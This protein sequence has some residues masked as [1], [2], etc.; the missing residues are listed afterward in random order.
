MLL[1]CSLVLAGFTASYAFI[2]GYRLLL[3]SSSRGVF[4]SGSVGLVGFATDFIPRHRRGNQVMGM[5]PM[6][7]CRHSDLGFFVYRH[8]WGALAR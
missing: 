8:G 1:V 4:W 7:A 3:V 5:S 2:P 6:L